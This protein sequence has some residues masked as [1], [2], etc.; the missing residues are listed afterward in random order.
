M[1]DL[2]IVGAG[3]VGGTL[4]L[5]LAHADLDIVAFDARPRGA[6]PRG[7]RSLALSHGA[8]LILERLGV[9]ATLAAREGAVT[10]IHAIDVSQAG[11]F[12]LT[13]LEADEQ[14]VPALGYVVAYAALQQEIDRALEQV[15]ADVRFDAPVS[16][17]D[18]DARSARVQV[19]STQG[20]I[21]ARLAVVAD[22]AGTS[23]AGIERKR[24]AY[25]QVALVGAVWT[26]RPHAG[27]AYERFTPAGPMALLPE[28]DH[29]GLVWTMRPDRARALLA[30]ADDAFLVALARAFGS[31]VTGFTRVDSLRTFPLVLE[32]AHPIVSARA[33]VIGNAAQQLH[34]VAGQ[35]FN[36]GLRDAWE[37]AS[38][39]LDTPR[40]ALGSPAMLA[41]HAA[42]RARDR[43]SGIAF[44]HG[45]VRIFGNDSALLR[46]PR[47]LALAALDA[48]PPVKRAFARTMLFGVR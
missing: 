25:D 19:D 12:G 41:R 37:L 30:L 17:V 36:L 9:W 21:S 38:I 4:A 10:P 45:L 28:R 8:R 23:V 42:R 2:A 15:G 22:G 7:D 35:G 32:R 27:V 29:Y 5:A 11:G 40:D 46:W 18:G 31:R 6:S 33:V 47:G 13:R 20:E 43:T 34:P 3:P 26:D 39:V 24:H 14:R 1:H 48:V 16:R 44:T